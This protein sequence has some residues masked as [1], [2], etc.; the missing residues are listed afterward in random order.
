[1]RHFKI[2]G[3]YQR[4]RPALCAALISLGGALA[5]PAA[6]SP[7]PSS[8]PPG[9]DQKTRLEAVRKGTFGR[10]TAATLE[11]AKTRAGDPP[12]EGDNAAIVKQLERDAALGQWGE[13][14]AHLATAFPDT[15]IREEA[16]QAILNALVQLKPDP[17]MQQQESR[18]PQS[19]RTA[20]QLKLA[21]VA[22]L[23]RMCPAQEPNDAMLDTY[24][25]LISVASKPA[26][27]VGEFVQALEAGAGPFGGQDAAA[28]L[29]AAK[30]LLN[31]GKG[32]EAGPFLPALTES[33][34]QVA[35]LN[36]WAR[37]LEAIYNEK[38]KSEDLDAAWKVAVDAFRAA[39]APGSDRDEALTK[40]VSLA[41]KVRE[42]KGKE[43][44]KEALTQQLDVSVDIL[45]NAGL[46]TV[47]RRIEVP[48]TERARNLKLQQQVVNAVLGAAPE[49][50]ADW[51]RSLELLALNWR[52]E[53]EWSLQQDQ[54][55][56]RGPQMEFDAFGNV[57]FAQ[58]EQQFRQSFE[59]GMVQPIPTSD[60]I[61]YRPSEAWI[62]A[63]DPSL[64]PGFLRLM[65]QLHLKVKEEN[66]AFALIEK[67]A[68]T[69]PDLATP[70]AEQF[71]DV[72]AE[73]NDPNN[74]QRRTNRYMYVYGYNPT[75]QGIPLTRSRQ[76]RNL[77]NLAGWVKR[78]R[79]LPLED[80][81]EQKF[82]DAFVKCHGT[83][84]VYRL[85]DANI[86]LG[87]VD[88]LSPKTVAAFLRIMR[89]NLAGQWKDEKVQLNAKTGRKEKDIR[90]QVLKGYAAAKE[91]AT[92]QLQKHPDDWRLLMEKGALL[93]DEN[94]FLSEDKK[95]SAFA[96]RREESFADFQAAA[97]AYAASLPGME[98][99]DQSADVYTTWFY[100]AMGASDL[101]RVRAEQVP[102]PQQIPLI[103]EAIAKLGG[104]ATEK[105]ETLF[106][107]TLA[108]RIS[109]VAPAVKQRYVEMGLPIAG[110]NERAKPVREVA[111]Y[112][113]DIVKEIAL[114]LKVDGEQ[115][116]G[117][118]PFGVWVNI[119]HTAEVEKAGG[120]FQKYLVNQ[121]NQPMFWN[122]GRPPENYRDKFSEG[123]KEALGETFD[124]QSVTFHNEKVES[125]ADPQPGWRFTPYAYIQLKPKGPQVDVIPP[126][127]LNLDFTE[128][129]GY[130]ILPVSSGRVPIDSSKPP[131]TTTLSKVDITQ[132]LDER[133]LAE[134]KLDLEIQASGEGLLPPLENLLKLDF[135]DF[136][137]TSTDDQGLQINELQAAPD[138]PSKVLTSR[139]WSLKLQRKPGAGEVFRFPTA[140][141]GGHAV[142]SYRYEGNDMTEVK[143]EVVLGKDKGI[144]W[145][146]IVSPMVLLG[147][148]VAGVGVF[149]WRRRPPSD[150]PRDSSAISIPDPLTPLNLLGFLQRIRQLP[151]LDAAARVQLDADIARVED[152]S[153]APQHKSAP[154]LDLLQIAQSWASRVPAQPGA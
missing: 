54:S 50:A 140:L 48:P 148:V 3:S 57:Y 114:D 62:D 108:T 133:K 72:W 77:E 5:A 71:L 127:K 1:M 46:Q 116:V 19:F 145:A 136:A 96:Q 78:I 83:A 32:E 122:F 102:S 121:N 126:L 36:L 39:S 53:A 117:T 134:G 124:I 129:G 81:R 88:D 66:E 118:E 130:V 90:E 79:A 149:L 139:V 42:P 76:I 23:M 28:R 92:A 4:V 112:Y 125:Q 64:Q 43:W 93:C 45:S 9:G 16:F 2:N 138:A 152:A 8:T 107:N 135:G 150:A 113:R 27:E 106:A 91:I 132:T 30:V 6:P 10:T 11:A 105:H 80:F 154:T 73:K 20:A 111:E 56:S 17:Q 35:V 47:K 147:F 74:E 98:E 18:A 51:R 55:T 49:R 97:A 63:L 128:T 21:D 44:L 61:K 115:P 82:L 26:P 31:A 40:L 153:Y 12:K 68:A 144:R 95:D 60:I 7:T 22:E 109:A 137:M 58:G 14:S 94:V 65:A 29:R 119:R 15:A 37:H 103:R 34:G 33:Q 143:G 87:A 99:K 100:A 38:R 141:A 24:V 101:A 75:S 151:S 146:W 84:E 86:V 85:E 89:T 41:D 131:A 142:T 70:L 13:L 52:T 110:E 25:A 120:G 69:R 59:T 104:E 123:M 67:V